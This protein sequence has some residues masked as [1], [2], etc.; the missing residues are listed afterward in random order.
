MAGHQT[1]GP[2]CDHGSQVAAT[3]TEQTLIDPVCGMRVTPQS[4]HHVSHAGNKYF[5]CSAGCAAKFA[6]D[7]EKYLHP[8]PAPRA[9]SERL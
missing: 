8:L 5:F 9:A 1:T 4:K 6:A 2:C 3:K 7:P